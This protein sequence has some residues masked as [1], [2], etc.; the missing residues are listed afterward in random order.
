MYISVFC[1]LIIHNYNVIQ[2]CRSWS[3]AC[4]CKSMSVFWHT[5]WISQTSPNH[6]DASRSIGSVTWLPQKLAN[7][8]I[9]SIRTWEQWSL[10]YQTGRLDQFPCLFSSFCGRYW[11]F[12]LPGSFPGS[13]RSINGFLLLLNSFLYAEKRG[14]GCDLL[15][16]SMET[17]MNR[18]VTTK[19]LKIVPL[20]QWAI[21]VSAVVENCSDFDPRRC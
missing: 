21:L 14:S 10:D 16:S 13:C 2:F 3:D 5:P 11:W 15:I 1:I 17:G 8:T 9:L 7:T 19:R 4:W 6:Q 18:S 12:W 20:I